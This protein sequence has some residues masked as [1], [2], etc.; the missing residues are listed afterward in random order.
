MEG[1]KKG[2]RTSW[3]DGFESAEMKK[4]EENMRKELN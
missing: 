4:K 2:Y 3:Q 1:W